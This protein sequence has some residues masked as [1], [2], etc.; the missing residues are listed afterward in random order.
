MTSSSASH[1]ARRLAEREARIVAAARAL[2]EEHG[3]EAVTTRRLA[4]AIGYSQP[5][6]YSHFP[7]GMSEIVTAVALVGFDELARAMSGTGVGDPSE[8][9]AG[10]DG[11]RAIVT[12]YLGYAERHPATYEAMFRLP[13]GAPFASE[14]TPRSMRVA[15][16]ALVEVLRSQ[17][18]P[19]EDPATAAEVLWGAV[20]GVATLGSAAR[21]SPGNED[22]RVEE[23]VRRYA[24]GSE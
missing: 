22:R 3:W 15:F 18:R 24:G 14:Q 8:S 12:A 4:D 1:K 17:E 2:A 20:H 11:L 10:A 9:G 6:L 5:V 13:I 23:L 19:P 21:L 16:D 7:G